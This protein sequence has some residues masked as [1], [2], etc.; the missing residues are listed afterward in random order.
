[1]PLKRTQDDMP[2]INLTP[3]IDIVFQLIIFFMVGARFTEMEKKL[4]VKVPGVSGTVNLP[5]APERCIVNVYPDGRI[6]FKQQDVSLPQL[7]EQLRLMQ[8]EQ[9]ELN[10]VLRGDAEAALKRITTVMVACRE[11]G[12]TELGISVQPGSAPTGTKER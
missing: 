12:I 11:A 1:M 7:K 2:A 8:A 5:N 3:M 4:D 6:V 9:G 10:V